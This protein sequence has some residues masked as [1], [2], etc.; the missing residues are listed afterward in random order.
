MFSLHTLTVD[1]PSLWAL[2][3]EAQYEPQLEGRVREVA[4][5]PDDLAREDRLSGQE[6]CFCCTFSQVSIKPFSF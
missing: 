4:G 5:P 3:R 6:D 1:F 2:A